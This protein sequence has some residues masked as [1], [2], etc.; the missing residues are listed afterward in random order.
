MP[1]ALHRA[2]CRYFALCFTKPTRRPLQH[3]PASA[4]LPP[5]T[6]IDFEGLEVEGFGP[7]QVCR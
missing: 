4:S 2:Y 3:L 1:A 5:T 6:R 7:F